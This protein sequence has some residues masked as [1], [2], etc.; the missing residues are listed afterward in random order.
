MVSFRGLGLWGERGS[1]RQLWCLVVEALYRSADLSSIPLSLQRAPCIF[2]KGVHR[3]PI[4][5]PPKH[6]TGLATFIPIPEST[7]KLGGRVHHIWGARCP[8]SVLALSLNLA[9]VNPPRRQALREV[10]NHSLHPNAVSSAASVRACPEFAR[11]SW[12]LGI[13]RLGFRALRGHSGV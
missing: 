3:N 1:T 13:S 12:Q 7:L 9:P 10:V 4:S 11:S 6:G 2:S 8:Q 5:R